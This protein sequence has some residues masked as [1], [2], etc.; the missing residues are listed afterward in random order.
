MV[1]LRWPRLRWSR[2]E[3]ATQVLNFIMGNLVR[4]D[5]WKYAQLGER[6]SKNWEPSV[7][8][9][10]YIGLFKK[11]EW[12]CGEIIPRSWDLLGVVFDIS[13]R[14]MT[15]MDGCTIDESTL[16]TTVQRLVTGRK[17]HTAYRHNNN[18]LSPVHHVV[19]AKG[20]DDPSAKSADISEHSNFQM[21]K[22]LRDTWFETGS[23]C[24]R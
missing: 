18:A 8:P 13:I 16:R 23:T 7:S 1:F 2:A 9:S 3:Q 24:V 17:S 21:H 22:M 6:N 10:L 5:E 4:R 15:I 11:R 12:V 14:F 19:C 20:G